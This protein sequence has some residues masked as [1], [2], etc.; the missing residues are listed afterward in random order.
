MKKTIFTVVLIA[1]VFTVLYY[2]DPPGSITAYILN[3][4]SLNN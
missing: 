3:I 4:I 1:A 2:R